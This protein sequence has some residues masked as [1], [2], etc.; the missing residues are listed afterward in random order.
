MEKLLT[1]P[2]FAEILRVRPSTVYAKVHQGK[3][4]HIKVGRLIRFKEAHVDEFLRT[5]DSSPL[6]EEPT[7]S[8]DA[9]KES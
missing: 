1:V 9:S 4:P 7:T 6:P 2:E 5:A 8:V 3:L